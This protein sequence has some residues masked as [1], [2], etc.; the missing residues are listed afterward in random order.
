MRK[1]EVA[2]N[3]SG[4]TFAGIT[5]ILAADA[6]SALECVRVAQSYLF[7]NWNRH[8]GKIDAPYVMGRS[9]TA[10]TIYVGVRTV[11]LTL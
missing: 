9:N 2:L 4:I 10:A 7:T 5:T 8:S 3:K 1:H 11:C 6:A